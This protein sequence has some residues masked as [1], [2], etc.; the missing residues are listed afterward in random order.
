MYGD[1]SE[2]TTPA[3]LNDMLKVSYTTD[4]DAPEDA[5]ASVQRLLKSDEDYV[6]LNEPEL[7]PG[8]IAALTGAEIGKEYSFTAN[9]AA[10]YRD[11][12]LA[13]KSV[14]YTVN[15]KA[16]QRRTPITVEELCQK[17]QVENVEALTAMFKENSGREAEIKR[18]GEIVEQAYSSLESQVPAFD[19]PE[20][21][22]DMEIQKEL[23]QMA[24]QAI[25]SEEDAEKFRSELDAHKEAAKA[26]ATEKLRKMLILRKVAIIEGVEVP[27]NELDAQV[28]MMARYYGYKEDEFRKMIERNGSMEDLRNDI[29]ANKVLDLLATYADTK[30]E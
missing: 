22:L 7:I 27:D 16:I 25:K 10:D 28:N 11:E 3:E 19:L 29:L 2:V 14:T 4:C 30:A 17:M 1:Y 13:G 23:N 24:N 6:W 26:P 15:V 8:S 18:R 20:D 9:F 12:F 5:S 21:L